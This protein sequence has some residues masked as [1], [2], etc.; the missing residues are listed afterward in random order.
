MQPEHYGQRVPTEIPTIRATRASSISCLLSF[1]ND[2][3]LILVSR[4]SGAPLKTA[5]QCKNGDCGSSA[6]GR[7]HPRRQ[8]F[9][10][11]LA[12]QF[13][14]TFR[15]PLLD[16]RAYE[17]QG[18]FMTLMNGTNS[19]S[20]AKRDRMS[21]GQLATAE[22]EQR[23]RRARKDRQLK[24]LRLARDAKSPPASLPS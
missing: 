2:T 5:V 14:P 4:D 22:Y 17:K 18:A 12:R 8:S 11:W 6:D 19:S 7:Q 23:A 13:Y 10:A 15:V 20:N 16:L 3:E 21:N 1:D 9:T 24:A